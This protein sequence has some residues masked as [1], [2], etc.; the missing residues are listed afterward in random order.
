MCGVSILEEETIEQEWWDG[1]IWL[2]VTVHCQSARGLTYGAVKVF[3]FCQLVDAFILASYK[4]QRLLLQF[5]GQEHSPE[6][7]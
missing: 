7:Y 4:R 2:V 6:S 1:E 5:R 3:R